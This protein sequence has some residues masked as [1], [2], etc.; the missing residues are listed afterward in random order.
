ML[1]TVPDVLSPALLEQARR[2]T[3]EAPWVDGKVTAGHQSALA[4]HNLQI[5]E[6]HRPAIALGEA[7]LEAVSKHPLFLA[8]TLPLK[9]FPQLFNRYSGGQ[10]FGTHVDNA[11]RKISGIPQRV[12]T[13]IS[14]TLFL[15]DPGEYTGG[16]LSIEDAYGVKRVKLPAGHLVLYASTSLHQVTPVTQ[17]ARTCAFFWIQS[18]IRDSTRRMILFDL[19]MAIQRLNADHPM[20]PSGVELIGVYHNLLRQ[21]AET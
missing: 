18:M 11:I 19:D 16:E 3:A 2:V 10:H 13:D 7:I 12:R 9:I 14:V 5:P 8:A 6:D 17:G 21:W 15:T 1:L 4:K 20:H